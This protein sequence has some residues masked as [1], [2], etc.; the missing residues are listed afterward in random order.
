MQTLNWMAAKGLWD[1]A[2][3]AKRV[4]TNLESPKTALR[5]AIA[6]HFS[7]AGEERTCGGGWGNAQ[8]GYSLRSVDK[9]SYYTY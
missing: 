7:S 6:S 3:P 2:T 4:E 9:L 8:F 5:T 1:A